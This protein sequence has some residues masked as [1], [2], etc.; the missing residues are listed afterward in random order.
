MSEKIVMNFGII[1]QSR[2]HFVRMVGILSLEAGL[3]AVISSTAYSIAIGNITTLA[4]NDTK[5]YFEENG[6]AAGAS[7]NFSP[8]VSLNRAD[9]LY[10]ADSGNSIPSFQFNMVVVPTISGNP[11]VTASIGT[12]YNFT[13]T[14]TNASSFNYMGPLLPGLN[15]NNSNG[16][17]S[18]IP[19][20]TGTYRNIVITAINSS[21]SASL[22]AFN[23]TV[24]QLPLP[25]INGTP[26]T[27]ATVGT[28]YTF[29]PSFTHATNFT[30]SEV[31][32]P[33]LNFNTATGTLSGTP[34]TDGTY[35]NF[36]ITAVNSSGSASL[37][38]FSIIVTP[39]GVSQSQNI[40]A[41]PPSLN[42]GPVK[43]GAPSISEAI[44]IVNIYKDEVSIS[45]VSITGTD[46]DEF[47]QTNT[48]TTLQPGGSCLIDVTFNPDLPYVSKAAELVINSNTSNK[49]VLNVT[50]SGD[51]PPPIISVTPSSL[52]FDRL[53]PGTPSALKSVTVENSG[54]NDLIIGNVT[55]SGPNPGDFSITKQCGSVSQGDTCTIEV[56]FAPLE[57]GVNRSAILDI[58]S[59]DPQTPTSSLKLSGYGTAPTATSNEVGH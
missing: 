41:G 54:L 47:G 31:E 25:T 3:L 53:P 5:S 38:A 8:G 2:R 9:P 20:T 42:F 55:I 39:G 13:P 48:C 16:A 45:E 15:F 37:P 57:Q 36:I 17:I 10:I 29:T 22:P 18:G 19:T 26:P 4:D 24:N 12:L 51:V 35:S 6:P 1:W 50:L 7:L 14:S 44:T 11:P 28:P 49:S 32:P 52:N 56:T 43:L 58:N 27:S 40:S 21:G 30:I 33:G 59:N 46:A 34:T 23:I